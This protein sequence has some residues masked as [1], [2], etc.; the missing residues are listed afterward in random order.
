MDSVGVVVVLGVIRDDG[1]VGGVAYV[2]VDVNAYNVGVGGV[3]MCDDGI[4]VVVVKVTEYVG[5]GVGVHV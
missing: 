1:G 2:D 4:L 5:V 3:D